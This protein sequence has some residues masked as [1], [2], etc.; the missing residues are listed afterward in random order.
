MVAADADDH[1]AV[2][3]HDGRSDDLAGVDVDVTRGFE[4]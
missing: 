4:G 3:V 2:D 1:A